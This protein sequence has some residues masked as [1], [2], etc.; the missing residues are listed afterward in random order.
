MKKE[1]SLK[2]KIALPILSITILA[3]GALTYFSATSSFKTAVSDAEFKISKSAE[4]FANA[5]K[6][7]LDANTMVASQL[8]SYLG[9]LA[10]QG[11][12][13][14]GKTNEVLRSMIE[15]APGVFGV[16]ATFNENSFDGQDSAYFGKPGYEK[17]GGFGPY[18]NRAGTNGSIVWEN[19]INYQGE[20]YLAPVKAGKAVLTEP[21]YDEVNGSN[22]LMT[23]AA[24]P[25]YKDK[26]LLGVVGIDILLTQLEKEIAQ[27][28]PFET[29]QPYLVSNNFTYVTN[30]DPKLIGKEWKIPFA[31][32]DFKKALQ[33]GKIFLKTGY[34]ESLK[35]D[36]LNILAPIAI[37]FSGTNWGVYISTPMESVLASAYSLLWKQ[38]GIFAICL[39]LMAAAVFYISQKIARR[40]TDLT[41]RL[42]NAETVVTAAID[43][44]SQAGQNLAQSATESAASIEETVASLEEMTSMVQLNATNAKEA[45]RLS[46]D[47]SQSAQRGSGEMSSLLDAMKEISTSSQQIAE[48][49]NVIDDLA[50]QTNL[51]ALNASVEAARAGEHG[52]GFAVVADAVRALAQKSATAAKDITGLINDSVEKVGRGSAK[53]GSSSGNLK[54]IVDSVS[55]VN[56][57]NTDISAASD[58]QSTGIQQISKAM[59]Q[60]DQSIQ[61]NAASAEEISATVQEILTQAN[62]MKT[63]VSEMT[64]VVRGSEP[65]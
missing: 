13:D 20:F 27:V 64:Q 50:F 46:G 22:L 32:E 57:L 21:Y 23:S 44:L 53:A 5:I 49:T 30:P 63:V 52:K 36:V 7:D 3:L 19:D 42:D 48:I 59:N 60:L 58:E 16:W 41:E 33:E 2:A 1:L 8:K 12:A 34:D 28:K 18:W 40:F 39:V 6:A 43:Q 61:T 54:E 51:L 31:A 24:V 35:K 45:A 56:A 65:R 29:S 14:R 26:T 38:L 11:G 10:L 15:A 55:K 62:I 47:S 9:T 17:V 25:I 4:S 37:P